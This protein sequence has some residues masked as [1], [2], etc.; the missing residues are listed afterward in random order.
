MGRTVK[1]TIVLLLCLSGAPAFADGPSFDCSQAE[2]EDE[3]AICQNPQLSAL[4]L[5]TAEAYAEIGSNAAKGIARPAM[6]ARH[7]CGSDAACIEDVLMQA[8]NGYWAAGA[9]SQD[10]R[11]MNDLIADW[12]DANNICRGSIDATEVAE[13]IDGTSKSLLEINLWQNPPCKSRM[14]ETS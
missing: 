6:K 2:T 12:N 11:N 10:A 3:V 5:A 9:T 14:N 4:E 7:A 1:T 13:G 8:L